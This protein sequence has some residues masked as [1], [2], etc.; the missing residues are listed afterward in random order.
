MVVLSTVQESESQH[1]VK[2]KVEGE[3]FQFSL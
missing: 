1:K 3:Y 2:L